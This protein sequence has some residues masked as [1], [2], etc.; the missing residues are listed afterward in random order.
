M[1]VDQWGEI[2]PP[3]DPIRE[4]E[5][6][7][8]L[9]PES[10]AAKGVEVPELADIGQ[11]LSRYGTAKARN[12]QMAAH[13]VGLGPPGVT[14]RQTASSTFRIAQ[15]MYDC[16]SLLGF[17][18]YTESKQTI[19]S[20]GHFC[21]RH[22]LCPV[23]AIRRGVRTLRSYHERALYLADKFDFY[24]VTL[25]VKN[26]PDLFERYNHLKHAFKRLRTRGR[27]GYGVWSRVSGAV[28]STEFTYTDENGW[29]PHLHVLV[30]VPK[31]EAP[32]RY[33]QGSQ[34]AADWL[35]VTG[36]SF[37]VHSARVAGSGD[38][39]AGGLCEVLKYALKFSD[40]PLDKNWEAFLI[41]KGKRLVQSS[42]CFYGLELPEDADLVDDPLDG[43]YIDLWFRY[44]PT[45]YKLTAQP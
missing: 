25:T 28:W 7:E 40:L 27:D 8:P 30:A 29:H 5:K 16:A 42:G 6:K 11:K 45:G 31:G 14:T 12:R 37:I 3:P 33:G 24:L 41:L 15:Q 34:L 2:H 39:L 22:L 4:A 35:A 43:P 36:D 9:T 19:L 21:K 32:I 26:G 10:L 18:H 23:C 20:S 38:E 13:I 44:G 1:Y 17:R